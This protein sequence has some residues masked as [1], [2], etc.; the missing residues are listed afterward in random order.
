M[1]KATDK[2]LLPDLFNMKYEYFFRFLGRRRRFSLESKCLLL[3]LSLLFPGLVVNFII[4]FLTA[5]YASALESLFRYF[6]QGWLH[7]AATLLTGVFAWV[8][9]RYVRTLDARLQYVNRVLFQ[10]EHVE[11]SD[12][13]KEHAQC[14]IRVDDYIRWTQRL[15]SH[16][17][18]YFLAVGGAVFGFVIGA[19]IVTGKHGWAT[20]DFQILYA[21]AW[22]VFYGFFA[23]ACLH[24]VGAG[25][26]AIREYCRSVVSYKEVLPLDPDHTGGLRELGK[27]SLDLDLVVAVPSIMFPL[28]LL[29]NRLFQVL[30][31]PFTPFESYELGLAILLSFLYAV[32]LALVFFGSISPAHDVMLQAKRDYLSKM[33]DEYKD[34]HKKL[35]SKLDTRQ[36][37]Q[38][39]EYSR[40]FG[41]YNLYDKIEKMAVWPLDF[42]TTIRFTITSLLPLLS[43]GI[44]LQIGV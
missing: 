37:I 38:P 26:N 9:I 13:D 10:P 30:E 35:L 27:L 42:R 3:V 20:T 2:R 36:T 40:L 16:K 25:Y 23:G 32:F 6:S 12:E 34:I 28:Y 1:S 8:L 15:T 5:N 31:L 33:H 21:K 29:R 17:W 22:Y 41:L 19:V 43:L 7:F 24:Y 44:T 11:K 18:Y 14:D 4:P 39:S